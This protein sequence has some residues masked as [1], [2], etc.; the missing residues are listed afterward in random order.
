MLFVDK[1]L[2][3]NGSNHADSLRRA[4][5]TSLGVHCGQCM[6]DE[7]FCVGKVWNGRKANAELK[8]F[9]PSDEVY[10]LVTPP[11]DPLRSCLVP[12]TVPPTP[13][14]HNGWCKISG[15]YEVNYGA[16]GP[17]RMYRNP[18]IERLNTRRGH[19]SHSGR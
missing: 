10:W 2:V 11:Q 1:S 12:E 19:R 16:G 8:I 3:C 5:A 7:G 9:A 4:I 17:M 15:T 6:A 18:K 13:C 14:V